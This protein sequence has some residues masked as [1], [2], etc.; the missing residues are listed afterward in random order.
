M[1]KNFG[2][3][4]KIKKNGGFKWKVQGKM[5]GFW[6]TFLN[7]GNHIECTFDAFSYFNLIFMKSKKKFPFLPI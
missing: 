1:T 7:I 3:K 2:F 5:V 4:L 6:Q